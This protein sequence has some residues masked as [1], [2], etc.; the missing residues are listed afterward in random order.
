MVRRK[1]RRTTL[2]G[3]K[4]TYKNIIV[5]PPSVTAL[6]QVSD[7]TVIIS[8]ASEEGR[9]KLAEHLE[10]YRKS[11][12]NDKDDVKLLLA[13]QLC[14]YFEIVPPVWVKDN[15]SSRLWRWYW[16]DTE[17]LDQAFKVVR[18]RAHTKR[19]RE[20]E[21]YRRLVIYR[22]AQERRQWPPKT[23]ISAIFS[24]VD[25]AF[26]FGRGLTKQIFYEPASRPY[27]KLFRV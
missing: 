1:T 18:P 12:E 3:L 19:R 17:T 5:A 4:K 27:R 23:P 7:N 6:G 25:K 22:V 24:A 16:Y 14:L 9:E 20:R 11:F 8:S 13:A 21:E 2:Q 26:G 10:A 15:F